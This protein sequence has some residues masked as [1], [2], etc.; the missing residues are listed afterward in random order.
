MF[1]TISFLR[2]STSFTVLVGILFM[3]S[4]TPLS[5]AANEGPPP[6]YKL[7]GPAALG[8]ATFT[9]N[10]ANANESDLTFSGNCKGQ[11]ISVSTTNLPIP[12]SSITQTFLDGFVIQ[13]PAQFAACHSVTNGERLVV[14]LIQKYSS[15]P[16]AVTADLILMFLVP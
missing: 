11:P 3:L 10:G 2:K 6:G 8:T 4:N 9:I 13:A 12:L 7:Q 16:T 14:Q 15:G 5:Q 1:I